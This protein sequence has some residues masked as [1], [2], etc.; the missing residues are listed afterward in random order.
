[1]LLNYYTQ[2][3]VAFNHVWTVFHKGLLMTDCI[4]TLKKRIFS[5]PLSS[6]LLPLFNVLKT[7]HSDYKRSFYKS[8]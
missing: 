2:F 8:G 4:E 6:L 1:M 3:R 5:V 7:L